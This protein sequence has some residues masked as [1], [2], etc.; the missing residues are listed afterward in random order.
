MA[1]QT[2]QLLNAILADIDAG[3]LNPGDVLDEAGLE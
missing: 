1:G 3:R 2:E